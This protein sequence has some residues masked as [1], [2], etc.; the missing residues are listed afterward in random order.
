ME[1]EKLKVYL[2]KLEAQYNCEAFVESDPISIPHL[3]VD[4][5]DI[6]ISAFLS[7]TIAWGKRSMILKNARSMVERMDM[8]PA[9]FIAGATE[10]EIINA[11]SGFVHRTFNDED[12][13]SFML[14]LQR[15]YIKWGSLGRFFEQNY[16][17]TGD[18]RATL[19]LFRQE[20]LCAQTPARTMR[21]V[22]SIEKGS[23]CKRLCMMLRWMVRNDDRGVDFGLWRSIPTSAL[24]IPLDVH[25]ARQGRALGLLSRS[26]DDWRAVEELTESL[27]Q[28]DAQ[29]PVRYDFALFGAGVFG[30]K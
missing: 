23:A 13:A 9:A 24:Y 12:F 30:E 28:F 2:D 14:A 27:R 17:S 6:E 25:S 1:C 18:I 20:F 10:A 4:Q 15:L 7:A 19:A 29:D 8:A 11:A 16:A 3:F 5:Q 26:Q 22:S 21:Q